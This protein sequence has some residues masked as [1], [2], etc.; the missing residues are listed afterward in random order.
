MPNDKNIIADRGF[1]L[2]ATSKST[3]FSEHNNVQYLMHSIS[4]LI[5]IQFLACA[6]TLT[7]HNS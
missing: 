5:V 6:Y 4:A 3:Y 1:I 2:Q 7:E